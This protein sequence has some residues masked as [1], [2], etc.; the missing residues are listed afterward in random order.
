MIP[1]ACASPSERSAWRHASTA[2]GRG[3]A[4]DAAEALAEALA[5]EQLHRQVELAVLALA[6]VEDGDGVRRREQAVRARLAH[7][8]RLGRLVDGAVAAEDLDRDLATHRVLLRAVDGAHR[9]R[10]ELREDGVPAL[11]GAADHRIVA[12]VDEIARPHEAQAVG[13]AD[14][15]RLR[16]GPFFAAPRAHQRPRLGGN[17]VVRLTSRRGEGHGPDNRP[18]AKPWTQ[19]MPQESRN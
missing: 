13:R 10:A 9:A 15:R 1:F 5:L 4:P 3:N 11:E 7:E 2:S 16:F 8:A 19:A 17:R 14:R 12:D 18:P 6:E